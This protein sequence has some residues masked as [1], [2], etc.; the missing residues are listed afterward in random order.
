MEK[1]VRPAPHKIRCPYCGSVYAEAEGEID[2]RC[3]R[4][5]AKFNDFLAGIDF[6]LDSADDF[7]LSLQETGDI[8]LVALPFG[9]IG[10]I[11]L[12]GFPAKSDPEPVG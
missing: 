9:F 12:P 7:V 5:Y 4:C 11:I 6:V 1:G 10:V 2:Y 3:N 8:L